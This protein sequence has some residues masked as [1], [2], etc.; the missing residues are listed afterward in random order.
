MAGGSMR[1]RGSGSWELRVYLGVDRDTGTRRYATR[2]VH[3]SARHARQALNEF[4][5]D[6]ARGPRVGARATVEVVLRAWFAAAS[7]NWAPSTV[8]QVESVLRRHLLPSLGGV[9]VLDLRAADVDAF[10]A[11]LRVRGLS[12]GTVRRIH[13]VLHSA[14]AQAQRWQWIVNNPA[15]HTSPPR[16][17]PN[18]IR[19]PTPADVALLIAKATASDPSL[20]VYVRLAAC[21]GARRSQLLALRWKDIDLARARIS[22]TRALVEG[23]HGPVLA[24]TKT[25]VA[26]RRRVTERNDVSSPKPPDHHLQHI[27][28][29]IG[30]SSRPAAARW[31]SE[32]ASDRVTE[33]ATTAHASAGCHRTRRHWRP[34]SKVV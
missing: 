11:D 18:E 4:A 19:P 9:S 13:G 8:R 12:P 3:G 33:A 14:L 22:F 23:L 15:A 28:T 27:N 31:A 25:H 10:Y 20:G 17:A 7:P 16:H 6:V 24:P 26:P 30:V 5:A 34:T 1:Q 32:H 2:T 21:T 29:Q